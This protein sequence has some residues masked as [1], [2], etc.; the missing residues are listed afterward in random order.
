LFRAAV[1]GNAFVDGNRD[2]IRQGAET[3]VAN[4]LVAHVNASGATLATTRTDAR[5][6]YTFQHLD[7]GT[8][9]V[10]VTPVD[11]PAVTSRS[12][13]VTRGGEVRTDVALPPKAQ[14]PQARPA[15]RPQQPGLPPSAAAFASLSAT[16]LPTGAMVSGA[17]RR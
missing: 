10:V 5:G 2:G 14:A 11:G 1:T 7:L 13:T 16:A 8:Y 17:K 9:R 12:V 6:N 3:G 4:A 15:P